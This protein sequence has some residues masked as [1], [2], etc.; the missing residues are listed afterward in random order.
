MGL[1][2]CAARQRLHDKPVHRTRGRLRQ[3]EDL[4][5][6][7]YKG[8][9]WQDNI[10]N[11][12]KKQWWNQT[13]KVIAKYLTSNDLPPDPRPIPDDVYNDRDDKNEK[14]QP[15]DEQI[16]AEGHNEPW[17]DERGRFRIITDS[18]SL[19]Q[20]LSGQCVYH[21]TKIYDTLSRI[22]ETIQKL[23]NKQIR[24]RVHS[25]SWLF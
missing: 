14:K 5:N 1:M 12:T 7:I 2:P 18:L 6:E 11:L 4:L 24:C 9:D 22:D 23:H 3:H 10:T 16:E 19:Q 13:R 15:T 25:K 17:H 21:G 8:T 20:I